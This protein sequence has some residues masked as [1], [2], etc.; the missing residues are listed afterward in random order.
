MGFGQ[1]QHWPLTGLG[2]PED[3]VKSLTVIVHMAL[4]ASSL[5]NSINVAFML[6]QPCADSQ[7]LWP[8][9]W[10]LSRLSSADQAAAAS[11]Q[12]SACL[13]SEPSDAH[14]CTPQVSVESNH[15]C[16]VRAHDASEPSADVS[17][18]FG[19]IQAESMPEQTT[20]FRHGSSNCPETH[21]AWQGKALS[22]N[23]HHQSDCSF[24]CRPTC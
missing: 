6:R 4:C 2:E 20:L 12:L 18:G 22:R 21:S 15:Q 7:C 17:L 23:G 13:S 8:T 10:H 24:N 9:N 11:I 1:L 16:S 5:K 14:A 19:L 3:K